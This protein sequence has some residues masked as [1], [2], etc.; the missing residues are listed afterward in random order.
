MNLF[1]RTKWRRDA[2]PSQTNQFQINNYE[3][4]LSSS[5]IR[6][7]LAAIQINEDK[8]RIE[9]NESEKKNIEDKNVFNLN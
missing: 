4:R 6:C 3:I 7:Y 5:S 8:I 2:T 9:K 1:I